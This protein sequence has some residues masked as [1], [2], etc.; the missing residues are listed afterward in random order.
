MMEKISTLSLLWVLIIS[1]VHIINSL[2]SKKRDVSWND[3]IWPDQIYVKAGE[4]AILQCHNKAITPS[5]TTWF[6]VSVYFIT[7]IFENLYF[8]FS[9]QDFKGLNL[10]I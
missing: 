2:V 6:K 4:D 5:L 7:P 8:E 9:M 1:S 3:Y 10:F